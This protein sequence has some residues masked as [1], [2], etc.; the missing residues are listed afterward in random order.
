MLIKRPPDSPSSEISP[1]PL[2]RARHEFLGRAALMFNGHGEQ[3]ASL[4]QGMDL[5]VHF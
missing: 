3:V 1:E 5:R 2:Y 4:H